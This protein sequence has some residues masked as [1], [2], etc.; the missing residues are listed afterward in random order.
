VS[1]ADVRCL[2]N[3]ADHLGTDSG[4]LDAAQRVAAQLLFVG[5]LRY[6]LNLLAARLLL[7]DIHPQILQHCPTATV[8][9]VGSDPPQWLVNT[10]C[11][12]PV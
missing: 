7:D 4:A 9:I 12:R 2:P 8:A 5:D 6:E 3:G 11:N 10:T 1:G